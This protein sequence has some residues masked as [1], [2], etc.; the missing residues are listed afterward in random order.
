MEKSSSLPLLKRG[1]M[2]RNKLEG[3]FYKVTSSSF[4]KGGAE[5]DLDKE[6]TT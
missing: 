3:R 1:T 4:R 6:L 2:E 5:A